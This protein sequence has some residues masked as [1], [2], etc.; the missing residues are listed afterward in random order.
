M[1]GTVAILNVA[2]GDTKLT[3]DSSNPD[4]TAHASRVVK[5]MLARGFAILIEIGRNDK[6]PIYQRAHDFDANTN[7]YIIA[8]TPPAQEHTGNDEE[9]TSTPSEG[10]ARSPRR[11]AAVRVPAET[12]TAVAVARTAGG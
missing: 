3:F 11:A 6:G 12:S 7:E 8:G 4:E 1:A 10:R 2:A 9:S 5:D